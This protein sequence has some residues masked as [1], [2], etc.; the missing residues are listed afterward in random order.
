MEEPY[1]YYLNALELP[2]DIEK[3]FKV[4]FDK[5]KK[6]PGDELIAFIKDL[7]SNDLTETNNALAKY[8]RPFTQNGIKYFSSRL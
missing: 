7:C 4:L 6:W 5:R 1:I 3:R 2:D 8:C